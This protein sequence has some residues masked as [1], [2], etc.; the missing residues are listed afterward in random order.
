MNDLLSDENTYIKIDKD[1]VKMISNELKT[2]LT[3]WQKTY[4]FI[5]T[6]IFVSHGWSISTGL[7][8]AENTQTKLPF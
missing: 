7:W 5:N 2:L 4:I 6:Q 8:F 1:P 3:R